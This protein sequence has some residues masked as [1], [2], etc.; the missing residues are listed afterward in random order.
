MIAAVKAHVRD[1][2][3]ELA[4]VN[5]LYL[6]GALGDGVLVYLLGRKTISE[7]V[8]KIC[9]A[10][11]LVAVA[12]VTMGLAGCYPLRRSWVAVAQLMLL[13]GHLFTHL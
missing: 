12:G 6:G 4:V 9:D 3:R 10:H 1:H 7:D 8:W 5:S 13:I 2:L 11:P